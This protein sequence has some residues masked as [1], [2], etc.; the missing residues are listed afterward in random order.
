MFKQY[1]MKAL[2]KARL[3]L[4]SL[5]HQAEMHLRQL[6]SQERV[7]FGQMLTAARL[8]I[9]HR[10]VSWKASLLASLHSQL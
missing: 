7:K 3:R 10:L 9:N 6:M 4:L 8:E 1:L 2:S 5:E